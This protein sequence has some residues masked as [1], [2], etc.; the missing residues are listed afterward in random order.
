MRFTN[1]GVYPEGQPFGVDEAALI[2]THEAVRRSHGYTKWLHRP[3]EVWECAG[4]HLGMKI[5]SGGWASINDFV[6]YFQHAHS[7]MGSL[8]MVE[9]TMKHMVESARAGLEP[10]GDSAGSLVYDTGKRRELFYPVRVK[11]YYVEA[12]DI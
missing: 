9:R 4:C 7:G 1:R 3:M 8:A 2:F 10:G 11:F 5:T 6:D 12:R